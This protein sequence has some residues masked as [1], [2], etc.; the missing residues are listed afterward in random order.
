VVALALQQ[1]HNLV[2]A[3]V[4][5]LSFPRSGEVRRPGASSLPHFRECIPGLQPATRIDVAVDIWFL[6]LLLA[7]RLA[8][9]PR[10]QSAPPC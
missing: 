6:D 2:F 9:R 3:D 5:E 4:H 1:L 8:P 10:K 7:G